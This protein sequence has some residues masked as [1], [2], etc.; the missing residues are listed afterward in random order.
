MYF[1]YFN[2]FLKMALSQVANGL[3]GIKSF[4]SF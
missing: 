2:R 3:M 4:T 1:Y